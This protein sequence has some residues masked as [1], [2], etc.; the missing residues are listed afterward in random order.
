M[1]WWKKLFMGAFRKLMI[2]IPDPE[3][4][5]RMFILVTVS[6]TG[7]NLGRLSTEGS[8]YGPHNSMSSHDLYSTKHVYFPFVHLLDEP[9]SSVSIVSGYG[10]DDRTIEVQSPAGAKD[11]S[12]NLCVQTG[13]GAHPAFCTMF[14]GGPFPGAKVRPGRNADLSPHLVPRSRM[15][16]SYI[17]SP[18][19]AFVACSG[20]AFT[21][22][23][24][25]SRLCHYS[26]G[27]AWW[28]LC[29]YE[30]F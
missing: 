28:H 1:Y 8:Y 13:S 27:G 20:T 15:S 12:S 5:N 29:F 24:S 4:S 19:S 26:V 14:T 3:H 23:L 18:P 21:S 16:R 11:F 6:Y 2:I 25:R 9:G 17:S 30:S 22:L 10:L 7:H